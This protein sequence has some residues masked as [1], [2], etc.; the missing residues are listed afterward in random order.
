MITVLTVTSLNKPRMM[1]LLRENWMASQTMKPDCWLVVCD[2]FVIMPKYSNLLQRKRQAGEGKNT[3]KENMLTGLLNVDHS[4]K[5]I[6]VFM[7]DDDY[8]SPEH[9]EVTV[10]GL[11]NSD[12]CGQ[13]A[14]YYNVDMGVARYMRGTPMASVGIRGSMWNKVVE[15]VSKN[16]TEADAIF[17]GVD[18]KL[19]RTYIGLKWKRENFKIDTDNVS[20]PD[21]IMSLKDLELIKA[22]Y[23]QDMNDSSVVTK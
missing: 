14:I 5:D 19:K 2:S 11:K 10:K 22:A 9:I 21:G 17:N 23:S 12:E 20:L 18:H 15:S 16:G 7:E 13:R 1:R 8:Y 3:F 6:I 4:D